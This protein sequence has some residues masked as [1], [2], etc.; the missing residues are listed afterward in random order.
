V[1]KQTKQKET[2]RN[3]TKKRKVSLGVV[4][5]EALPTGQ[6]PMSRRKRIKICG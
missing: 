5:N 3:A 6:K 1:T 2:K 4:S